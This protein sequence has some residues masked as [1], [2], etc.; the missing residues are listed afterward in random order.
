MLQLLTHSADKSQISFP[1][2]TRG[3]V[4]DFMLILFAFGD[5]A[6][7]FFRHN[8]LPP[9]H[10]KLTRFLKKVQTLGILNSFFILDKNELESNLFSYK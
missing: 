8:T 9:T 5:F 3:L 1:G 7:R 4:R 10:L 6:F 2:K